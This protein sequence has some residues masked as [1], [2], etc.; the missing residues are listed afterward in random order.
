VK[1]LMFVAVLV[2]AAMG[3]LSLAGAGTAAKPASASSTPRAVGHPAARGLVRQVG[4]R[5][6]AGPN[7]PGKG[8]NCTTATRVVQIA[9]AGGTN[10]FVCSRSNVSV[11]APTPTT[12][13]I[14]QVGGATNTARCTQQSGAVDLTLSCDIEQSGEANF[15]YVNQNVNQSLG[16]SQK[17]KEIAIVTQGPAS[18]SNF[19]QLSQAANQ[20]SK[21]GSSQNQNAD[22]SA[23]VEQTA[24]GTGTNTS[25]LNQTQLQKEYARS[26]TQS[27]NTTSY[28]DD[29]NPNTVLTPGPLHPNVCAVVLQHSDAGANANQ[30]RQNVNEDQNSTGPA[31]QTQG[32]PDGGLDSRIHQDT[33]G[34]SS[35]NDAALS[36]NQHQTAAAST[37]T[38]QVQNDPISCCGFASQDGGTNNTENIDLSSSESASGDSSPQQTSHLIGTSHTPDGTCTVTV[39]SSINQDSANNSDTESPCPFLTLTAA[40]S[41]GSEGDCSAPP[42]DL[43]NPAPPAS[44]LSKQVAGGDSGLDNEITL[45]GGGP[46]V[47]QIVYGNNGTGDAH[48]VVVTD[49]L[50]TD[51]TYVPDSCIPAPL[52]SY[53]SDTNTITWRLGTVG[54]TIEIGRVMGFA[55]TV[56]NETADIVNTA[57]VDTAE[58]SPIQSND[59]TVHD[60]LAAPISSLSKL[61]RVVNLANPNPFTS[62]A[63]FAGGGTAEFQLLYSNGGNG[64]AHNVVVRDVVPSGLTFVDCTDSCTYDG[65]TNTITWNLGDVSPTG[66]FPM[67]LRFTATV[68]NTTANFVN[69]ASVDTDEENP[70]SSSSATVHAFFLG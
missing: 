45:V 2:L 37:L 63:S 32:S 1:K 28:L 23:T 18:V 12:C 41:S 17:S 29:C 4:F 49:T 42:P 59:A 58:E 64:D 24:T 52:C 22:Q 65:Q 39:K 14:K 67:E 19:L 13:V 70:V 50:P 66:E 30:L 26:T 21:T 40:C 15:A 9:T 43:S 16:S 46:V 34:G 61:V 6:Y 3:A 8:W 55:A 62:D 31:T 47:Y 10:A 68:P 53:D 5:N 11:P 33:V 35:S 27:Q 44:A 25:T 56:P 57:T 60:V 20:S 36:K 48:N 7:C 51:A 38:H 54:P 69:T